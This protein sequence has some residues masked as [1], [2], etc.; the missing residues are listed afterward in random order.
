VSAT[1]RCPRPLQKISTK[2]ATLPVLPSLE[3]DHLLSPPLPSP[4]TRSNAPDPAAHRIRGAEG[5]DP[6]NPGQVRDGS[7]PFCVSCVLE[8][9][10][11]SLQIPRPAMLA[12]RTDLMAW[13]PNFQVQIAKPLFVESI[14]S[15]YRWPYRRRGGGGS[16]LCSRVNHH[17]HLRVPIVF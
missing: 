11:Y 10:H 3:T 4:C 16:S 15:K 8:F 14:Q 12:G 17:S 2:W 13:N 1:A 5:R 7:S 9:Y 6:G